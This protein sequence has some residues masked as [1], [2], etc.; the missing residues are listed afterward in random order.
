[1]SSIPHP[2]NRAAKV[3]GACIVVAI[4]AVLGAHNSYQTSSDYAAQYPDQYGGARAEVRFAPLIARIPANAE[5]GYFT[6]LDPSQALAGGVFLAAQYAVA[7][8]LLVDLLVNPDT[9]DKPEWAVG[10]FSK[11]Q[12]YAAAGEAR[13]YGLVEDFGSGVVL[14]RR[15]SS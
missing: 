7:P 8:R 13:G 11:P 5:V 10:N 14:F 9:K 15:K 1:V 6:D 3:N 2:G 12:D 4:L